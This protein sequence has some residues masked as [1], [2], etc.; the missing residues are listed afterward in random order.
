MGLHER[1]RQEHKSGVEGAP[2]A[3]AFDGALR[4]Y[5][6]RKVR[7]M[8]GLNV[9]LR[10]RPSDDLRDTNIVRQRDYLCDGF[11]VFVSDCCS[12]PRC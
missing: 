9:A 1:A 6:M 4:T 2:R 5:W 8:L 10:G 7:V 11:C 12:L 3:T